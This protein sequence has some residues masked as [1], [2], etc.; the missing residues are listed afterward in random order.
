MDLP[1]AHPEASAVKLRLARA[2]LE[3]LKQFDMALLRVHLL[4]KSLKDF[5]VRTGE[6]GYLVFERAKREGNLD[7]DA[8]K[9]AMEDVCPD[10]QLGAPIQPEAER[11][12]ALALLAEWEKSPEAAPFVG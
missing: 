11:K 4:A 9:T 12:E 7:H 10:S 3:Q 2:K 1:A 6:Q 5:L 8:E